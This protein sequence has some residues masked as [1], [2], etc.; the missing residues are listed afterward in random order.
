[1]EGFGLRQSLLNHLSRGR[2]QT[3]SPN[4]FLVSLERYFLGL[5]FYQCKLKAGGR[6][7]LAWD[8]EWHQQEG[9]K[10]CWKEEACQALLCLKLS[11]CLPVGPW[12]MALLQLCSWRQQLEEIFFCT[13]SPDTHR[14]C[15]HFIFPSTG[16]LSSGADNY[17]AKMYFLL[18]RGFVLCL[19]PLSICTHLSSGIRLRS[20][21]QSFPKMWH[22]FLLCSMFSYGPLCHT[23][24]SNLERCKK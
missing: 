20:E 5:G 15:F 3:L 13:G 19:S 14:H 18:K 16:I 21:L 10:G 8:A 24:S 11:Q 7:S 12:L 9:G 22:A 6:S 23:F 17:R 2:K 1:M 4:L